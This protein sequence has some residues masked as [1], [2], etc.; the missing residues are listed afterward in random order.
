MNTFEPIGAA[1]LRG[2]RESGVP[3]EE[4]GGPASDYAVETHDIIARLQAWDTRYG[5]DLVS[6]EGKTVTL[7]FDRLPPNLSIFCDE[8]VAFCPNA[9]LAQFEDPED[10]EADFSE[11]QVLRLWWD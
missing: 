1:G 9:V 3:L 11:T 5:V 6:L 8:L 4:A 2:S 10:F 7:R